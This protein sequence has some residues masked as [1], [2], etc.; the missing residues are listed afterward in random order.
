MGNALQHS[1]GKGERAAW[2]KGAWI[3]LIKTRV[4][5]REVRW[6]LVVGMERGMVEMGGKEERGL[7]EVGSKGGREAIGEKED[8]AANKGEARVSRAIAIF[9]ENS[10]TA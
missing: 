4:M 8:R 3:G 6:E 5:E 2:E 1:W 9:V 7:R 10:D